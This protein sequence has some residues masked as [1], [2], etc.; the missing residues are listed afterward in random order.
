ME[1]LEMIFNELVEELESFCSF[2]EKE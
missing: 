1:R 2:L